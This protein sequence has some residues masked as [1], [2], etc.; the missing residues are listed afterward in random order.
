VRELTGRDADRVLREDA[1]PDAP[2]DAR[3][4]ADAEAHAVIDQ[5]IALLA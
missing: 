1:E 3:R 2:A 5:A 4:Q